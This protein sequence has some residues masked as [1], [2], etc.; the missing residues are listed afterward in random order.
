MLT[1][2]YILQI[3]IAVSVV[4]IILF[5][6]NEGGTGLLSS[7][8]YNSFFSAKGFNRN[9]LTK[10]TVILGALFFANAVIIGALNITKVASTKPSVIEKIKQ[11]EP[12]KTQPKSTTDVPLGK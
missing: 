1:F 5:Q 2:F 12:A 11:V 3:I 9:P 4:L 7:N 10:I 6:K 8:T